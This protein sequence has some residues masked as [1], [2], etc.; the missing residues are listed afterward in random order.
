MN[1][2]RKYRASDVFDSRQ[3]KSWSPVKGMQIG[4]RNRK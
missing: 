4:G 3:P 2:R 1:V